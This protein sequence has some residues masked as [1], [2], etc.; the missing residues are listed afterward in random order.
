MISESTIQNAE[1]QWMK[2]ERKSDGNYEQWECKF[3]GT[4]VTRRTKKKRVLGTL[5]DG[6]L[7]SFIC[8]GFYFANKRHLVQ[9]LNDKTIKTKKE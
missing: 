4:L 7:E 2:A 5:I 8:D 3:A 9:Y 6:E 1:W